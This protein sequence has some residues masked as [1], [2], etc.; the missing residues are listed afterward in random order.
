MDGFHIGFDYVML[1]NGGMFGL[2]ER[3]AFK[4]T[5]IIHR[6]GIDIASTN[7]R[8]LKLAIASLAFVAQ[9]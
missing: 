2:K 1:L 7:C 8:V 6:P 5:K 3:N 4:K 9:E